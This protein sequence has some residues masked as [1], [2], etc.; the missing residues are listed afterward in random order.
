D[1]GSA[2]LL[3][4]STRSGDVPVARNELNGFAAAVLDRNGVRPK[5]AI[6]FGVRL[7]VDEGGSY[8]DAN[9]V[10][11]SLVESH[12]PHLDVITLSR[13]LVHGQTIGHGGAE[14]QAC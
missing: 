7:V 14:A 1:G 12:G 10:R 11:D 6:V 13:A 4:A 9:A 3:R 8:G 2:G 5:I